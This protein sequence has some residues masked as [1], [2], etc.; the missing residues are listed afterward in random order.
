MA[1]Y[2]TLNGD[3][4]NYRTWHTGERHIEISDSDVVTSVQADCTELAY[5]YDVFPNIPQAKRRV[6]TWYGEMANFIARN[7]Y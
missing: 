6:V 2:I 3:P 7:L 1:L 4:N 5:I